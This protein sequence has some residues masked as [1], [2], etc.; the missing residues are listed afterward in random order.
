MSR[1]GKLPVPVPDGVELSIKGQ[2]VSAKG[3]KG[4]LSRTFPDKVTIARDG[5]VLTVSRIDDS[6]GARAMH[7]LS[8]TLLSNMVVGV[9]AG[10]FKDLEISGTGYRGALSGKKLNLSIGFSHPVEIDPPEGITFTLETPVKLRVAG[11]DKQ[12]VGEVA[13]RIRRLR[14]P[15]PYKA[16]GIKYAT[17]RIRRKAGKAGKVGAKA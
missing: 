2:D 9:T 7:G 6:P 3:P 17:E 11:R 13:A 10:F 15:D 8:R 4:T 5:A 16:K 12:L 1:I 14:V